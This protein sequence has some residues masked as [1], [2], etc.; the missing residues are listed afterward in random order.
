MLDGAFDRDGKVPCQVDGRLKCFGHSVGASGLRMLFEAWLQLSG[1]AGDRQMGHAS[2]A[3]TH[4]I[5]GSLAQ[6]ICSIMLLG[7]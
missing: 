7:L 3:L 4:N 2:L 5:G 6:N 1:Q